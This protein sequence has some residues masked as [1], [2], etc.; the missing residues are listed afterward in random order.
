MSK[1]VSNPTVSK[2]DSSCSSN[3]QIRSNQWAKFLEIIDIVFWHVV[4]FIVGQLGISHVIVIVAIRPSA[5][6]VA[7]FKKA[8]F[9]Y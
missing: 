7:F 8:K 3:V 6:R 9:K 4:A 5:S 1:T 2:P